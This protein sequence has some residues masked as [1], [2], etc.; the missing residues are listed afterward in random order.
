MP[1]K[2]S[3]SDR[4]DKIFL[5]K[6]KKDVKSIYEIE[7]KKGFIGDFLNGKNNKFPSDPDLTLQLIKLYWGEGLP[8][9]PGFGV[10]PR[11]LAIARVISLCPNPSII[12]RLVVL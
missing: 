11:K 4:L 9:D 6:S 5:N 2:E 8:M 10:M 3:V 12:F 7:S 1:Q